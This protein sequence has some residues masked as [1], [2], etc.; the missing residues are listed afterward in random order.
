MTKR[1]EETERTAPE[2]EKT[3]GIEKLHGL[4]RSGLGEKGWAEAPA[5]GIGGHPELETAPDA[6]NGGGLN[7]PQPETDL[8]TGGV[9]HAQPT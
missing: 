8:T 3:T 1:N 5:D 6:G 4:D 2:T 7:G 9:K